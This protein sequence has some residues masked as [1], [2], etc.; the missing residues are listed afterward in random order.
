[1]F[2]SESYE[3]TKRQRAL[4]P[5]LSLLL[6]GVIIIVV[7]ALLVVWQVSLHQEAPRPYISNPPVQLPS[8]FY[9]VVKEQ[10][11]QGLHL[12]TDQVKAKL[13]SDEA[14]GIL[15]IAN[16]QHVSLQQLN[17]LQINALQAASDKMVSAGTWTHQQ[18]NTNMQFWKQLDGKQVNDFF[19]HWFLDQ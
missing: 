16:A 3:T 4:W 6:L 2:K 15:D 8:A 10:F 7:G 19:T 18:A 9:G 1:M 5:R 17:T 13:Q 11:A 12:T 14:G